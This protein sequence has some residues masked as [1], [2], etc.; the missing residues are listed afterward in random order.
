MPKIRSRNAHGR[1]KDAR[2]AAEA[3]ALPYRLE[4]RVIRGVEHEVKV[5]PSSVAP[6]ARSLPGAGFVALAQE[7]A[8]GGRWR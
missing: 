2:E 8:F 1:A 4:K 5:Y 6:E 7:A 3:A